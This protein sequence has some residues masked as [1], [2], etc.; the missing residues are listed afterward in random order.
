MAHEDFAFEG[1][2]GLPEKPPAGE[3]VL[4][5]GRPSTYALLRD[6][7]CLRLIVGYFT[8][9]VIWRVAASVA[10]MG[11]WPALATAVPLVVMGAAAVAILYVFA[12][13]QARATVY[14]ITTHRVA[15]RIGAALPVTFNIPFTQLGNANLDLRADGTGTIAMQLSGDDKISYLIAWPHV[16][17]WRIAET[18]PSLRCVPDAERIARILADAAEARLTR[19]AIARMP[20]QAHAVA[21]E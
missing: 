19:P 10:M 5:Q 18:E 8:A 3:T 20:L 1:M 21:A 16:R 17:P 7:L 4:W 14:T 15:L 13:A 12:Y 9:L 11:F 6:A 2:R